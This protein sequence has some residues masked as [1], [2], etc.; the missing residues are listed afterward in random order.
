MPPHRCLILA[1]LWASGVPHTPC[2]CAQ[3]LLPSSPERH[4]PV[5][6]TWQDGHVPATTVTFH[7]RSF[8]CPAPNPLCVS[9]P[10]STFPPAWPGPNLGC[11][12]PS[13]CYGPFATM[14]PQ[15]LSHPCARSSRWCRTRSTS[16]HHAPVTEWPG[17]VGARRAQNHRAGGTPCPP[18]SSTPQGGERAPNSHGKPRRCGICAG[19]GSVAVPLA[20]RALLVAPV[21][22]VRPA[23][24]L[25]QGWG[26]QDGNHEAAG[27][28]P[29]PRAPSTRKRM[30]PWQSRHSLTQVSEQAKSSR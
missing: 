18:F 20:G 15:V 21:L 28:R 1:S 11:Q 27:L 8:R 25:A 6:D 5:G 26:K 2:L 13:G 10:N 9:S 24:G 12:S 19:A 22:R 7:P 17:A 30:N 29:S 3:L 4:P 23:P 14:V 16:T